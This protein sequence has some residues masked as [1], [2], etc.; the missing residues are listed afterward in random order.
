MVEIV[1]YQTLISDSSL[2]RRVIPFFSR[3]YSLIS[4]ANKE[5]RRNTGCVRFL[6]RLLPENKGY[7]AGIHPKRKKSTIT[8][9]EKENLFQSLK[10]TLRRMCDDGGRDTEKD[11]LGQNGG[12]KT[13]LSKNTLN[14]PCPKCGGAIVKEAYLGGAIYYCPVCQK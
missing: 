8:D 11:F 14:K 2:S 3:P 6:L 9:I 10:T 13:I 1:L 7:N 4:C 12:Y 5:I